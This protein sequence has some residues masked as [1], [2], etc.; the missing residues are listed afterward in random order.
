MMCTQSCGFEPRN[1]HECIMKSLS[2]LMLTTLAVAGLT[3]V[4]AAFSVSTIAATAQAKPLQGHANSA[5]RRHVAH[6]VCQPTSMYFGGQRVCVYPTP[7][8]YYTDPIDGS[9]RILWP[10]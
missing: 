10:R 8:T 6:S 1:P 7:Y 3:V 5:K 4:P 9:A 2:S